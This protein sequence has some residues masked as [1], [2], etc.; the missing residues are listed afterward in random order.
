MNWL[1]L[2]EYFLASISHMYR[3]MTLLLSECSYLFTYTQKRQYFYT[4][5]FFWTKK[6]LGAFCNAL[7]IDFRSWVHSWFTSNVY[8]F[9]DSLKTKGIWLSCCRIIF[10]AVALD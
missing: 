7:I 4:L 3:P 1:N 8:E 9:A 5:V 2:S 6:N 10:I